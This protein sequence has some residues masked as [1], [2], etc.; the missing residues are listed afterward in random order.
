MLGSLLDLF[1]EDAFLIASLIFSMIQ[2]L[3]NGG[4]H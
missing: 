2:M 3:K 1:S 4:S